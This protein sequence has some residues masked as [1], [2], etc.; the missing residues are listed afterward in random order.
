MGFNNVLSIFKI[1]LF[2]LLMRLVI[3]TASQRPATLRDFR[4]QELALERQTQLWELSKFEPIGTR[5]EEIAKMFCR[6]QIREEGSRLKTGTQNAI[7]FA[8]SRFLDPTPGEDV[9]TLT[10]KKVLSTCREKFC[11]INGAPVGR[12]SDEG[13]RQE[14]AM[15]A[16]AETKSKAP[17]GSPNG[18]TDKSDGLDPQFAK[19]K[20]ELTLA[21]RKISNLKNQLHQ[22]KENI[23][24]ERAERCSKS[25]KED[26][27]DEEVGSKRFRQQAKRAKASR[28]D[29]VRHGRDSRYFRLVTT[30]TQ[31][32]KT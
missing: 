9:P 1:V 21:H 17:F 29:R 30:V 15:L 13:M 27:P 19:L 22:A 3:E 2:G 14:R 16:Q 5:Q 24:K 20:K 23:A 12:L 11:S 26:S 25:K 6:L 28:P 31:R 32:K 4:T 10:L 8:L 18:R 7:G